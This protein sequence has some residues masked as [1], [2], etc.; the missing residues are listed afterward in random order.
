MKILIIPSWYVIDSRPDCGIYFRQL[1]ISLQDA[2]HKVG[3]VYVNN[4]LGNWREKVKKRQFCAK[5]TFIND[6]IPTLRLDVLGLPLRWSFVQKKYAQRVLECYDLFVTQYGKPDII[7]AHGYLAAAAAAH[8]KARH[9][10]PYLYT[11]HASF[12]KDQSFPNSHLTMIEQA[13]KNA[14]S[15]TAVSSALKGWMLQNIKKNIEIVPNLTDTSLFQPKLSHQNKNFTFL[16]VGDLTPLK[17]PHHLLAAFD[18]F[19]KSDVQGNCRLEIIGIGEMLKELQESVQKQNL[20]ACVKF[21]RLLSA[22]EVVAKMQEA[23]CLVLCSEV[24][25][26]G[27]VLIEAM[28][29]GLPLIATD[30][31]GPS[32]IVSDE[33]GIL[34][35]KGNIPKLAEAMKSIYLNSTKWNPQNIRSIALQKFGNE[36]VVKKWVAI[37]ERINQN[38]NTL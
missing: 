38:N 1:A 15:I 23:R 28:A 34:V 13:A 27:V 16:F 11:E 5:K 21:H 18:L 36:A 33:V 26:F 2:D 24:E 29:S 14:D 30:C 10:T 37:Y 20:S 7:H 8:I 19:K 9:K 32:D 3:V 31:G 17:A 6:T 35:P 12:F 4:H 22:K 25:T